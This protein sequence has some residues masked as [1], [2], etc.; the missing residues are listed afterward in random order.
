MLHKSLT[1]KLKS[2][3]YLGP[4]IWNI[5]PYIRNSKNIEGFMRKIK[6]YTSKYW[7]CRLCLNY[8]CHVGYVNWPNFLE[9]AK[10]YLIWKEILRWLLL[11]W[12][13]IVDCLFYVFLIICFYKKKYKTKICFTIIEFNVFNPFCSQCSLSLPPGNIRELKCFLVFPGGMGRVTCYWF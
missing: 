7:P 3:R 12:K 11:H 10:K 8:I 2:L 6:C 4:K 13:V 1:V 9:A 5:P